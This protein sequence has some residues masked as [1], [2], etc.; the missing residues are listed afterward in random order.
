MNIGDALPRN[1]QR[2]PKKLAIV[3]S[4]RSLT[5]LDFH[6]RTNRLADYF[7]K[8]GIG[9]GDLVAL[10]C[11]SRAE[12]FETIFAL[13]KI[14][15][16]TVPFDYHWSAQECE[17]MVNFFAP[18]A[19]VLEGR[20]ETRELANLLRDRVA[21]EKLLEI[22]GPETIGGTSFEEAVALGSPGDP[23]IE[24]DSKDTFI[25]M[26]TSGTTGFPKACTV[27]HE[28]YTLRSLNFAVTRGT[29]SNER[30]L[31]VLPVHFNAGR[32]SV[33]GLL[34][35]GATVFIQERFDELTF[36]QTVHRE[37]ITYT[38]L[39]PTLCERLLRYEKLD[40][41]DKR[42]LNY[43]SITGGHLSAAS[44]RS[45]GESVCPR[46]YEAYASTDCGQVTVLSPEDRVAHGESVGKPIWCVRVKIADDNGREL[47]LGE[48]GEICLRTP[49]AIQGYY[50]N[51]QAT[52]E[53][54]RNG[55]CHTGD[56]GFLDEQGYLTIS[57]RK[58]NMVKS[59]GISVFPEEIEDALRRH[60][61]VLDVAV[62]GFRSA[63]WGEAVKAFVVLKD[64]SSCEAESL[65]KFCKESLAPY[66][67][68]KVVEFL[69]SLPRTGLG[70]IDRGKLETM[71][72]AR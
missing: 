24:V 42:S 47:P 14:G 41:F 20:K 40:Q 16:V 18:A 22:E 7:I 1:A 38:I 45:F 48:P 26:I 65:I 68:P 43:L 67:A 57:G 32:N 62:T 9:K 53:F 17:A 52:H 28:T 12:H 54:L 25:V 34:Y 19:F 58:K 70:K 29:G 11:G 21:P 13:A 3:D 72:Q 10:S 51:P 15:A 69:S 31:M 59:G 35:M 55:W 23:D 6:L 64:G 50:H 36:L 5:F 39:V 8:R 66:K 44:A 2:F 56:I 63:E 49:T 30:A 4:H 60:P 71:S 61:D 33:I 27:N 37:K 46:F